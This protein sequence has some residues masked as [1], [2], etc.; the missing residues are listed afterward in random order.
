MTVPAFAYT[1]DANRS[2]TIGLHEIYLALAKT[3]VA[4]PAGVEAAFDFRAA[5]NAANIIMLTI[6]LKNR[7]SHRNMHDVHDAG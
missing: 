7:Q 5:Y 3:P 2:L 4:S 6:S 1:I